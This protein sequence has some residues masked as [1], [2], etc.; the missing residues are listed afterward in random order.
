MPVHPSW[1]PVLTPLQAQIDELNAM[2]AECASTGPGFLPH[3]SDIWRA[4]QTP[5]D[6]VR[7]LI[8]GQDPYPT[9]GH[10]MGLA[11]STAPDSGS[12]PR[13]LANIFTELHEDIGCPTPEDGD[14]S[15]WAE[16]GVMLLNTTLTV[17]PHAAGA[18]ARS[19]WQ[20]VTTATVAALG[21]HH[22][23]DLVAILWGAHAR[24]YAQ[25]L[26]E[27]HIIASAH[28][29][30]LSARRGFFGSRPFSAANAALIH[31]GHSPI[32]WGSTHTR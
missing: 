27:A 6:E 3:H 18:H 5:L 7:V 4:Y 17:E 24:K 25:L 1:R 14:L 19:G 8:L 16:Q 13:S 10:A 12:V 9:P 2:L 29:S 32:E 22:G 20:E 11:F 30:P 15:G 23:A 21:A 28:P 26:P 31:R